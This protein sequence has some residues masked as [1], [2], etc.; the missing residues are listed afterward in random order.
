VLL[1]DN[2]KLKALERESFSLSIKLNFILYKPPSDEGGG[3]IIIRS[4]TLKKIKTT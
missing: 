1:K 4:A 3:Q 2:F